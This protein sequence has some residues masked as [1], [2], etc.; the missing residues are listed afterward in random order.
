[1]VV[2]SVETDSCSSVVVLLREEKALFIG[3]DGDGLTTP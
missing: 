1:M 2:D 3:F